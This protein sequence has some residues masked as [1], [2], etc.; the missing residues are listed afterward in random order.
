MLE[1]LEKNSC[2]KIYLTLNECLP[3]RTIAPKIR[4]VLE[5]TTAVYLLHA[6]EV[7]KKKINFSIGLCS[8]C[9]VLWLR[10]EETLGKVQ[11]FLLDA[12]CRSRG[13]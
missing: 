7:S 2:R 8:V 6:W 9:Q 3:W 13:S 1:L 12:A 11:H 5:S 10:G 4:P